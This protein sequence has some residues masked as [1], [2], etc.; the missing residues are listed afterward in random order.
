M[1]TTNLEIAADG[2]KARRAIVRIRQLGGAGHLPERT[3]QR[4][5][6]MADNGGLLDSRLRRGRKKIT[7]VV[8]PSYELKRILG[9]LEARAAKA[10]A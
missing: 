8:T 3:R 4:L 1:T 2:G 6:A 9:R 10:A 5:L 7:L